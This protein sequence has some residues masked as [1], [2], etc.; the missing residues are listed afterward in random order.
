MCPSILLLSLSLP[1]AMRFPPLFSL[2]RTLS[3]SLSR[4]SALSHVTSC[5]RRMVAR[6][7]KEGGEGEGGESPL[8][9]LFNMI[10]SSSIAAGWLAG[11]Q[12]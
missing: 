12:Q 3:L 8:S 11:W 1:S 5:P 7:E 4:S 2:A 6:S 10:A 9:P